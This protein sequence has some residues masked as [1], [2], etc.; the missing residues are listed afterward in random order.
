MSLFS[1]LKWR[2]YFICRLCGTGFAKHVRLSHRVGTI[3]IMSDKKSFILYHD[4][5]WQ[6]SHL[7]DEELGQVTRAIFVYSQEWQIIDLPR[8]LKIVFEGIRSSLDR[9]N[10]QWQEERKKR[11]EAWKLW[12][13]AK[14]SNAKQSQAKVR[15]AKQKLA[16]LADSV[17]VSEPVSVSV[18]NLNSTIVESEQALNPDNRNHDIQTL[19]YHIRKYCSDRNI[20]YDS[21]DDRNFA[22]HITTAKDFWE[23]ADKLWKTRIETAV[24]II[25]LAEMDKFWRGKICWPKSIYQNRAKILNN[26]RATFMNQTQNPDVLVI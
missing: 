2:V 20:I 7:T 24:A 5:W 26:G 16:N 21:T 10:S 13:L 25:E 14:A 18:T 8:M 23:I 12:G 22:R 11:A 17:S 6:L 9:S 1:E 3:D 19:I 4:M 15:N